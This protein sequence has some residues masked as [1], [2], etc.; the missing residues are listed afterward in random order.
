MIL[1]VYSNLHSGISRQD[2]EGCVN[3]SRHMKHEVG[4]ILYISTTSNPFQDEFVTVQQ[5]V[6]SDR[7]AISLRVS[8]SLIGA[9]SELVELHAANETSQACC[10]IESAVIILLRSPDLTIHQSQVTLESNMRQALPLHGPYKQSDDTP[11][12]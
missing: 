7:V 1:E 3:A 5:H 6:T 8:I 11:N 4:T 9:I 10:T 2:W 12:E